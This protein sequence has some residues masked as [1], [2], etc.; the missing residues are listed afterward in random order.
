MARHLTAQILDAH[1]I[2]R[3]ADGTTRIACDQALIEDATGVMCALQFEQLGVDRVRIP[4][5]VMYVDHNVLQIDERNMDDHRY[6]Q[7]FSARYGLSHSPPGNGISHYLHQERFGVPGAVLA[8]ADSHSC[9]AGAL[10]MLGVGLGGLDVALAMAGEGFA[11][12]P[13]RV[14]RVTL[15][16]VLAPWSAAKDVILEILRRTGVRGGSGAI[17]EFAGD[18]VASLSVSE[19]GTIANMIVETGATTAVFP[20]DERTRAWLVAQGRGDAW[21]PLAAESGARYDDELTIDLATLVPLIAVPSSPG[22]VVTVADVAGEAVAQVCVGSSVNSSYD[23]L[24]IVAAILGDALVHP[25]IEVTAT[26]GSRQI[27]GTLAA[28][29]VYMDLVASGVRMLEPV[30]GPCVGMGQAPPVGLP[31][32]RTFNRNFPGRSGTAGDR[33]YLCSPETAAAT[34]LHGVITDPR[35]LGDAP[36]LRRPQIATPIDVRHVLVPPPPGT[37]VR[38]VRGPNIVDPPIPRAVPDALDGEILI[39]LPD[40]VSTGDM[41]PD[42]ALAM[43]IWANI[44]LCAETMFGR[45]DRTFPTRARAAGGGFIVAG[46]NYGQGSSRESA[47]LVP[48]ELGVRAIVARSF[49]RIHRTNLIAQGVVPLVLPEEASVRAGERWHVAGLRDAVASGAATVRVERDDGALLLGLTLDGR[50]RAT[51]LAGGALAAYRAARV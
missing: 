47:A 5:A 38:V 24:A 44:P 21:R 36:P 13:Q 30:C 29:G 17:F 37:D 43:A 50:E 40:D 9:M 28:S 35:T 39:V 23:D 25:T 8:G 42:G 10:G 3:D 51:L 22:N 2:E 27:L 32:V 34:A 18:G 33:V 16:G 14:V 31:S 15:R 46:H 49:A 11:L 4:L 6:L 26:P 48:V 7:S 20:S 19:R 45:F 41:A 12:A 1:L